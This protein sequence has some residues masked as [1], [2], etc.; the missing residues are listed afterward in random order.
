MLFI[1]RVNI[2]DVFSK[3]ENTKVVQKVLDESGQKPS[4][5]WVEK[6]CVV[7]NRSMKSWLKDTNIQFYSTHNEGK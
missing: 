6:G 5:I 2:P 1:F 7:Y 3:V 4:K